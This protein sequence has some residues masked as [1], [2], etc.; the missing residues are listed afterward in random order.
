[1]EEKENSFL[2]KNILLV[3][4]KFNRIASITFEDTED[5]SNI[6]HKFDVSLTVEI[7]STQNL[8]VVKLTSTYIHFHKDIIEVSAE[9]TMAG[10]YQGKD[11]SHEVFEKMCHING[12]AILY[13]YLREQ[14]SNLTNKA[15]LG[16]II[17]PAV[18]FVKLYE[19]RMQ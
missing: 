13:P 16:N 3:D 2:I 5:S 18:N 9:I 14:L 7:D 10:V 19:E 17:L 6:K 8:G 11:M 12:S 15:G 4:C 1:M